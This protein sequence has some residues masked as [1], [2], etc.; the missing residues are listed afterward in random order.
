ME[1]ALWKAPRP[2]HVTHTAIMPELQKALCPSC[3]CS[4]AALAA[5][6]ARYSLRV[7]PWALARLVWDGGSVVAIERNIQAPTR[8]QTPV[9][10]KANTPDMTARMEARG[11]PMTHMA[12][13]KTPERD[14]AWSVAFLSPLRMLVH[15]LRLM[16]PHGGIAAMKGVMQYSTQAGA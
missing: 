4:S 13:S 3:P 1:A 5:C 8:T 14:S 11:F 10:E 2:N 15:L 12:S 6:L 16:A 7:M 9:K